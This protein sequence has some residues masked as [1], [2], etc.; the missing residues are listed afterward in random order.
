MGL[1]GRKE[2]KKLGIKNGNGCPKH[3]WNVHG[4]KH[5]MFFET[6]IQQWKKK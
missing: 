3:G 5:S 6:A 1:V 2:E 4:S